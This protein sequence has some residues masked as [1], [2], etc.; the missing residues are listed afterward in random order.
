MQ[1]AVSL[2]GSPEAS[3]GVCCNDVDVGGGT[4]WTDELFDELQAEGDPVADA[5]IE[6]HAA[7]RPEVAPVH[8]V[9]S[10]AHHLRLPNGDRSEVIDAYLADAPPLPEW[11]GSLRLTGVRAFD[12]SWDVRLEDNQV[13][14]E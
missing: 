11:A 8:F 1:G 7:G 12:R 6:R 14:V 3:D 13:T 10:I 9:H 2:G 4:R 5:V